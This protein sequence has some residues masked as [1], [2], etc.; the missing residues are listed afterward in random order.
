MLGMAALRPQPLP[1]QTAPTVS[2]AS[3]VILDTDIVDDIDDAFALALALRSPEIELIGITTAWG[4]TALRAKLANRL[5][6]EAGAQAI[7]ERAGVPTE[8]KSSFTQKQWASEGAPAPAS[9]DAGEFPR[10]QAKKSPVE[11][12]LVAIGPLTKLGAA[13]DRDADGFRK[14]RRVVLMGGS[15]RRGYGDLGYAPDRGPEPEYNIYCD[16]K[17]AGKLLGSGVP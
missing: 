8:S 1:V 14:F 16:V 11:I 13:I 7:P 5:L 17:A 12:T 4:D 9:P 2:H 3:K 15:I 10:E 6:Q